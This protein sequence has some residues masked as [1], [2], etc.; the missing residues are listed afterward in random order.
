MATKNGSITS[1]HITALVNQLNNIANLSR[2]QPIRQAI[3]TGLCLIQKLD[4]LPVRD[5]KTMPLEQYPR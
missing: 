2:Y 3:K 1:S 4:V 5:Y